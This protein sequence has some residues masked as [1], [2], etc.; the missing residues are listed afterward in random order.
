MNPQKP[1]IQL[2]WKKEPWTDTIPKMLKPFYFF[3]NKEKPNLLSYDAIGFELNECLVKFNQIK[4][5]R[6]Y[7]AGVLKDL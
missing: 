1:R 2:Y 7:I 6:L 5:T 3:K 4:V